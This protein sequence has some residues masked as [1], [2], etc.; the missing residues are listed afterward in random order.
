MH[1]Q[2]ELRLLAASPGVKAAHVSEAMHEARLPQLNGTPQGALALVRGR[3][4][5]FILVQSMPTSST[6]AMRHFVLLPVDVTRSLGGNLSA[7]LTLAHEE[8]PSFERV[9]RTL[10]L[11][12]LEAE[13]AAPEAQEDS[14]LALMAATRDRLDVIEA[15]LAA[16]IQGVPIVVQDAPVDLVMRLEFVEG[17]LALLPPPAR[18]GVTFATHSGPNSHI[19]AQIRFIGDEAP[20]EGALAYHWQDARVT[21]MKVKDEY[22]RFIKSQLRLDTGLVLQQTTALTAVAAWRI[23]RGD[24]LA[25]ALKYAAYRLKMDNAVVNSQPVATSEV[26]RALAEDPTLSEDLRAAYVR[27][28]LAFT[29]A[30]DEMSHADLLAVLVRGQPDL[31]RV[32]LQQ[33]ND[34]LVN[35]KA[36]AV[37]KTL[38][39]WLKNPTGFKGMYWLEVAHRAALAYA[40]SL[41]AAGNVDGLNTFLHESSAAGSDLAINAILPQLTEIALP[42]G[43]RSRALAETV[44]LLAA[45]SLATDR[46]QTLLT[47][48]SLLAQL[49]AG[50]S[51]LMAY[52]NG[53]IAGKAPAG[54]LARAGAEFGEEW[55]G[56][57]IIRLVEIVLLAGR[58]D[59]IDASALAAL[60][61]A[62]STH[63][64][65]TYDSVLRWMVRN[66]SRDDLLPT[67]AEPGPRYLMQILLARR[68]YAELVTEMARQ[69]RVL[70]P[71]DRQLEF[72]GAVRAL[73]LETPL[74]PSDAADA[75]H[76]LAVNGLKTLPLV[77]AYLG[78]LQRNKWHESL[79]PVAAELTTL[80]FD[81]RIILESM[82]VD[83]LM[84]L[85]D[86][87]V[88]RR[89]I[90]NTVRLTSVL[91]TAAVRWGEAGITP[92]IQMYRMMQWDDT[93]SGESLQMLRRYVRRA[94]ETLARQ[95][96]IQIGEM[97]S[98]RVRQLLEASFIVRRLIGGE[99]LADY[100]Y[101]LNV[102]ARFL[103][104]TGMTYIDKNR[105]PSLSAL[106]S[107]LDSL[108]GGL[109]DEERQSLSTT[110]LELARLVHMLGAHHRQTHP[111]ENPSA[112]AQLLAGKGQ[113]LSAI[114][115]FRVLGGYFGQ[116]ERVNLRGDRGIE[117]HPLADRA[118]P[119]MLREVQLMNRLLRSAL[120]AVPA[121]VR[122]TM[123]AE[124]I[125]LE[126][127]SLWGEVS[128]Q[129]QRALTHSLAVDLQRIPELLLMITERVDKK[130][131][132]EDSGLVRKLDANRQ[133]PEN[134]LEFYRFVHGYFK[135][136]TR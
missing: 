35:G 86:F 42:L 21:G 81:N 11:L 52:M 106:Q 40:E 31:E 120:R 135:A 23:K 84:D 13:Q 72:A 14:M 54:L 58:N 67:I 92:L 123:N 29:L 53:E 4:I 102:A 8:A 30:L 16:I 66:L 82:P 34:A 76:V 98:P 18:F 114:D 118:A 111:R 25:N 9:G 125:R 91:P 83:P 95:A 128:Q 85:L 10:A 136:R 51:Y 7:L 49:P 109:T 37:Y 131:F 27:H 134:A 126:I 1:A 129:E 116:G 57:L 68:A 3:T 65:E 50:L 112:V 62:A 74:P 47:D 97:I 60:A 87:F 101:T 45:G 94:P 103:N 75:L 104:D 132:Q 96:L 17:L 19:E 105:A 70:Y 33:M 64:G 71:A 22:S 107:D 38:V 122:F 56:L 124:V 15:L 113:A 44:F 119:I 61:H 78:T 77:N 89:D 117:N 41:A 99:A 26:A 121:D 24:T 32:V 79:E 69:G 93:V 36:E 100:A 115:I 55:G 20:P 6:Q 133:R 88:K 127:E 39:S 28:L 12:K 80:L 108:T 48:K 110:M 73:F 90:A 63:W 130:L 46:W 59:L 5:P 2:G 43:S